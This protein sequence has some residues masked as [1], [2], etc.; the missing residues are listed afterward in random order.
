MIVILAICRR[1]EGV[2]EFVE[3][4]TLHA[5]NNHHYAGVMRGL[6]DLLKKLNVMIGINVIK[7]FLGQKE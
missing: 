3:K 1:H 2:I 4:I 5:R 7:G 6:L